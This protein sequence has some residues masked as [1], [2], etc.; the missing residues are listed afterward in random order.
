MINYNLKFTTKEKY[1]IHFISDLHYDHNRDFV[2]GSK[3]RNYKNVNQMNQDIIQQWN[4]YVS[5]YDYVW[6]LGDFVFG[7]PDASKLLSLYNRLNFSRLYCLFGNHTSG[8]RNIFKILMEEAGMENKE[9]FP[10]ELEICPGKTV[11]FMGNYAE[12]SIDH[13]RIVL[14]HYPIGS[15]NGI[16]KGAWHLHGHSHGNFENTE[17]LKRIDIGWDYKCRP[18]SYKELIPTMNKLGGSPRDHHK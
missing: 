10:T 16:G 18:V 7:D 6:H 4:A 9:V 8:E 17:K 3:G 5:P 13:Q 12:M 1:N 15:W 14:C 2:W 11:I